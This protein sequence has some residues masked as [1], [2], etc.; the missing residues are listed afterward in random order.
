VLRQG[1]GASK[2]QWDEHDEIGHH[3]NA[4]SLPPAHA[5]G[6]GVA[7]QQIRRHAYLPTMQLTTTKSVRLEEVGLGFAVSNC[8]GVEE[9][10]SCEWGGV[11][12][13]THH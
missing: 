6:K 5:H 2:Y 12:R 13:C 8:E 11:T 3:D 10:T 4:H 9:D 7:S 1:E